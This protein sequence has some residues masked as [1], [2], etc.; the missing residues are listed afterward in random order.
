MQTVVVIIAALGLSSSCPAVLLTGSGFA[1]PDNNPV[2]GQSSV[3]TDDPGIITTMSLRIQWA[4]VTG[5][6]LGGHT[7]V[8]DLVATLRLAP[9]DGGPAFTQFLF[10]RI[11]ATSSTSFGDSSDFTGSYVF[12]DFATDPTIWQAAASAGSASSVPQGTYWPSTRGAGFQ[13]EQVSL[14]S[15]F[16][17][18]VAAGTWT[19]NISDSVSG[20]TGG[21]VGWSLFVPGAASAWGL[22]PIWALT[23]R[24]RREPASARHQ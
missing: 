16:G 8:G 10:N 24:R 15:V 19:L 14:M 2:G 4:D 5:G 17:G 3:V 7:W 6:K 12:A 23:V 11:G 22:V 9:A 1:I 13:Y 20:D 21:I 18:R